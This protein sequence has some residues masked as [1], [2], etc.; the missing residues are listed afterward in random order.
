[1][2]PSHLNW[3]LT[4]MKASHSSLMCWIKTGKEREKE[5]ERE[6]E[7]EREG[8]KKGKRKRKRK[9]EQGSKNPGA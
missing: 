4:M 1:M 9:G 5:R 7:R 3:P 8:K 2:L 6:R